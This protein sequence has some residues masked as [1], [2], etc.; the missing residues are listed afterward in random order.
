M[1]RAFLCVLLMQLSPLLAMAETPDPAAVQSLTPSGRL[2][3]A[4]NFGNPILVQKDAK[5]G[6]AK[7]VSPALARQLASKL[8]VPADF[9]AYKEAG[10]VFEALKSGA[11]D[12]A[13]LAIEPARAE[14]IDFT[15]PYVIIEGAYAVPAARRFW[16]FP[17][18]IARA[19][20]SPSRRVRPM[21]FF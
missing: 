19:C 5:T 11:W 13:F 1:L 2:R 14:S 10:K 20:A 16:P 12:I 15:A 9:I 17:M 8:G 21:I 7:G 4:I 18:W 3:V 6:E